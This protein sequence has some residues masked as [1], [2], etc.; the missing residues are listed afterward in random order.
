MIK[1]RHDL[2]SIP[3][4]QVIRTGEAAHHQPGP[5]HHCTPLA[6]QNIHSALVHVIPATLLLATYNRLF[7]PT[8][9]SP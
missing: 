7:S 1:T 6:P 5:D 2:G 8:V 4:R 9:K 3:S